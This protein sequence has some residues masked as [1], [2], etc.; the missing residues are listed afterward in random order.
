MRH[1]AWHGDRLSTEWLH[2]TPGERFKI[3][4]SIKKT[5]GANS[6]L[7]FVVDP[8]NGVPMHIHKNENEHFIILEVSLHIA[9]GEKV[10]DAPADTSVT[11]SRS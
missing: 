2:V 1:A 11:V 3:R 7:E 5:E 6:M 8:R 9:V 4:T 10:L